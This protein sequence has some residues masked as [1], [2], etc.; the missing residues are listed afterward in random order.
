MLFPSSESIIFRWILIEKFSFFEIL[1]FFVF[2]SFD[3][4]S[5]FNELS[6]F[7]KVLSFN[8][9]LL[10]KQTATSL[11]YI[12]SIPPNYS[13]I[14]SSTLIF[15]STKLIICILP[16][17]TISRWLLVNW[18]NFY[19]PT[20]FLISPLMT[21]FHYLLVF[22]F[23]F[24]SHFK[25]KLRKTSLRW[26]YHS[27]MQCCLIAIVKLCILISSFTRLMMLFNW[28]MAESLNFYIFK[29]Q[30]LFW[31]LYSLTLKY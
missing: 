13:F 3:Q 29:E 4:S 19:S 5:F 28:I 25:K 16:K 6:P 20:I 7:E 31:T 17:A 9:N 30:L 1:N 2:H 14:D 27:C 21:L 15:S 18:C 12:S 11:I 26:V 24:L 8:F 10:H 23:I 22:F